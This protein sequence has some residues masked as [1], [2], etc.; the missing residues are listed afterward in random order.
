MPAQEQL[1]RNWHRSDDNY[2]GE[3]RRPESMCHEKDMVTENMRDD[4]T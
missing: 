3:E 2:D 4:E 1:C